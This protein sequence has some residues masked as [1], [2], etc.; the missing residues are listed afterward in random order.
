AHPPVVISDS[1]TMQGLAWGV[2]A[3]WWAGALIGVPLAVVARTG[4]GAPWD[5]AQLMK[6][7]GQ[8]LV[9][10]ATG[11][12]FAGCAGYYFA[13]SGRLPM[14]AGFA[15]AIPAAHHVRFMAV[16]CAHD[17][18]YLLGFAGGAVLVARVWVARCGK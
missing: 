14:D 16:A 3:T 17:A 4:P 10:M 13:R 15:D 11:A 9:F 7:V 5:A 2:I 12:L 6:P 18:S 8:L 1:P